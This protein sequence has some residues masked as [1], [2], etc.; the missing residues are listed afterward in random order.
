MK[1]KNLL[2]TGGG[3]NGIGMLGIIST[4]QDYDILNDIDN[5]M[6]ISV[7]SML[8]FF[9]N[10]GYK[11]DI[12]KEF[13]YN[14][15]LHILIN[16][17]NNFIDNIIKNYG[18]N[19]MNNLKYTLEKILEY[20]NINKNITFI[21]LFNKTNKILNISISNISDCKIEYH[22]YINTPNDKII[23]SILISSCIPVIFN[24]F[25]INNKYYADGGLYDNRQYNFYKNIDETLII[26]TN[27]NNNIKINSF[28]NYL[29]FLL[30]SKLFF[31][32][33]NILNY[34]NTIN[35][36]YDTKFFNFGLNNSE[37]IKL[38]EEGRK[39]GLNYIKNNFYYNYYIK[40]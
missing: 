3:V 29:Y 19:N 15:D 11:V 8:C 24:P 16:N 34:P 10:I 22:N 7:G 40:K 12:L 4:L 14:Y 17:N 25:I 23:N 36:S 32:E 6:G 5:Y 21:E 18:V 13:I 35:F 20:K 38:F 1:F 39:I 2:I 26:T 30:Y 33:L 27:N 31:I 28:Q 37:K 9:L